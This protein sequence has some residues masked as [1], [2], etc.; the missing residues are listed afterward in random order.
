MTTTQKAYSVYS[1]FTKKCFFL[2]F[3]GLHYI[4]P[5]NIFLSTKCIKTKTYRPLSLDD[6]LYQF[7]KGASEETFLNE[8]CT[9]SIK[10]KIFGNLFNPKE[11]VTDAIMICKNELQRL[12][13]FTD[14][15]ANHLTMTL[16]C[17]YFSI[18]FFVISS[19]GNFHEKFIP[20]SQ[21]PNCGF[22]SLLLYNWIQTS[23]LPNNIIQHTG[24]HFDLI[25]IST[26][27]HTSD[28]S[29]SQNSSF[30]NTQNPNNQTHLSFGPIST[31]TNLLCY[32]GNNTTHNSN[33]ASRPRGVRRN[34]FP[35]PRILPP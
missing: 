7:V 10:K 17:N 14:T 31:S 2:A 22:P 34:S 28:V 6:T 1:K 9:D 25:S 16:W 12:L 3:T 4:T 11:S 15:Q 29:G 26:K 5:E 18:S 8:F 21:K 20:M 27:I 23:T 33:T 30:T 19:C 35:N 24:I 13:Q 32:N